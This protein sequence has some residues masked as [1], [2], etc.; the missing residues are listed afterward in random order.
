MNELTHWPWSAKT[1]AVDVLQP[2]FLHCAAFVSTTGTVN[3]NRSPAKLIALSMPSPSTPE[4]REN[5]KATTFADEKAACQA[6]R[7][8]FHVLPP[9]PTVGETSLT[10]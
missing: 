7:V 3:V 5:P 6:A 10:N 2:P 8:P 4:P 1:G 9:P